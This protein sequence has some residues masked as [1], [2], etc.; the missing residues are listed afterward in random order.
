M[1]K[2]TLLLLM[3]LMALSFNVSA[4][5]DPY[6]NEMVIS[7]EI[8]SV[9]YAD[10]Y[11]ES[12]K[13][14]TRPGSPYVTDEYGTTLPGTVEGEIFYKGF[15]TSDYSPW[16]YFQC[17]WTRNN[18]LMDISIQTLISGSGSVN[19]S[20]SFSEWSLEGT[21]PNGLSFSTETSMSS[22]GTPMPMIYLEHPTII[23]EV[24]QS[25]ISQIEY[26]WL[27]TSGPGMYTYRHTSEHPK[28][29]C[30]AICA[31]VIPNTIFV[32]NRYQGHI[33][34]VRIPFD[35][36]WTCN[37]LATVYVSRPPHDCINV[38]L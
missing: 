11:Y 29:Q 13:S 19:G 10:G 9:T 12:S 7:S 25:G 31:P 27:S 2:K 33:M 30:P 6:G 38:A 4:I 17:E 18:R 26:Q 23:I 14:S 1:I 34:S 24:A 21:Y 22:C 15:S 3:S 28:P 37:S 35:Q 8:Q 16:D 20:T 5:M 36:Y 32:V